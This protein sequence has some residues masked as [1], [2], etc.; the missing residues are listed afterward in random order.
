MNEMEGHK[1]PRPPP[2]VPAGLRVY[3]V[4]DIHGRLDLLDALL[5]RIAEDVAADRPDRVEVVFLGDVVDRGPHSR[6][7]VERLM[8]GPPPGPLAEAGWQCLRGNHEQVILTVREDVG[9]GPGWCAFGGLDTV[10][11]YVTEVPPPG[12]EADMATVQMLLRRA[13]PPAHRRFL[14]RLPLSWSVGDYLFV[15]AGVRPGIALERQDPEDLLWIR[16]DFLN[17][18]RWHGK[19]VVHGHT[20]AADPQMRPNRIGID[21]RAYASGHLTALVLERE[22]RRFLA[23]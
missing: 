20:P 15:H 14:A 17:D 21:T 7:V 10:R 13:L 5:E 8:A 9:A 19:V 22:G 16:Q 23:T 4:G 2:A 1:G 6:G 11:S 18:G 12:W 3:A